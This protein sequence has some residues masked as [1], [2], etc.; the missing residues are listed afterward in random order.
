MIPP[1]E[2]NTRTDAAVQT[3]PE[4]GMDGRIYLSVVIKQRFYV[5][6]NGVTSKIDGAEIQVADKP[7]DDE[8]PD[9][10]RFPS[11][12][13]LRK[14]ST[15]VIVSGSA[16]VSGDGPA[17]S[18]DVMIEV[19]NIRKFL[20]VFGPRVWYEGVTGMALTPPQPFENCQLRWEY[21]WGGMEAADGELAM[22]D[23]NPVGRGKVV[24]ASDLLHQPGP[25]IEDPMH[26]IETHRTQPPPAGVAAIGRHWRPRGQYVGTCDE[27]W[28]QTRMPLLPLDFDE[29]HHQCAPPDQI[30]PEYLRGGEPVRV[31][32]MNWGLPMQF[33]LPRVH[34]FVGAYIDRNLQEFHPVMDTVVLMPDER[35]V[36]M[37]WRAA[38]PVPRPSKRISSVQVHDKRAIA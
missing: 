19:A 26:L 13:C 38:I 8:V 30:T 34:Y 14:P 27:E 15:D 1:P 28:M 31:Q 3:F 11:D 35:A 7:W 29:R 12:M 20:R 33:L 17:E 5:A 32:G 6:Q 4:I 36:D 23:R 24:N 2:L 16:C 9:S 37:V 18:V 10:I 25:Q 21:A 22:E